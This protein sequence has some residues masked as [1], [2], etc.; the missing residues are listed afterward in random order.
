MNIYKPCTPNGAC[1]DDFQYF[2]NTV[3]S[4]YKTNL[5]K[6]TKKIRSILQ[7]N[8]DSNAYKEYIEYIN[9]RCARIHGLYDENFHP[10]A[11]QGHLLL[12]LSLYETTKEHKYF[13][14]FIELLPS[15]ALCL[16]NINE[17]PVASLF[18]DAPTIEESIDTFLKEKRNSLFTKEMAQ[19]EWKSLCTYVKSIWP[20]NLKITSNITDYFSIWFFSARPNFLDLSIAAKYIA[21][22]IHVCTHNVDGD[23]QSLIERNCCNLVDRALTDKGEAPCNIRYMVLYGLYLLDTRIQNHKN[24]KSYR[25]LI[26]L[27]EEQLELFYRWVNSFPD[28]NRLNMVHYFLQNATSKKSLQIAKRILP[29]TI[30]QKQCKKIT[31]L[32]KRVDIKFETEIRALYQSVLDAVQE[33]NGNTVIFNCSSLL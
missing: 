13:L 3:Q 27:E 5:E 24:C 30:D 16:D 4:E 1:P 20:Q 15:Y 25:W 29:A 8:K 9:F 21:K 7:E 10:V 31:K 14:R 18:I 12:F 2:I 17:Q 22:L 11:L 6:K 33:K 32:L 28:Q 26:D 23:S 19:V